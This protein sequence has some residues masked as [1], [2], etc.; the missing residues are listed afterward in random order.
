[1]F[2][3]WVLLLLAAP[4]WAGEPSTTSIT[5]L[6]L[7][8]LHGR[9]LPFLDKAISETTPVGGAPRLA[10]MIADE[11]GKNPN[12]T[13]L[14]AAGDMFQGAPVS[15]VFRGQPVIAVMNAL[16]FDAMALGNHE[17][18]WGRAVL[19]QLARAAEF[20]F[21]AANVKDHEI[22]GTP[23]TKPYVILTRNNLR[24]AVLGLTTP[25]TPFIAKPDYVA[26]F[27][28]RDPVEI[29]PGL[30]KEARGYGADFIVLLS[31]LGL[32]G[33]MRVAQQV[34][35]I[36]VIIGGHSHTVM[37]Q[38]LRVNETVIV[39]AGSY[40][41]YLGVLKLELQPGAGRIVDYTRENELKTASAGPD[42]PVDERVAGIVDRFNNQIK[43][44]F[45]RVIGETSVDLARN[46]REESNVGNLVCDAMRDASG[47]DIAFQN[48]GA[49]RADFPKGKITL[50][51]VYTLL[52]FDN[53]VVVM[54][55]T[56]GQIKQI[57]EQSAASEHRILQVSG[58]SVHYD[59]TKPPGSM[60]VAIH[61]DGKPLALSGSY[62]VVTNEF[63]AEG[64]DRFD[65]FREGKHIT[66]GDSLRDIFTAY[67]EKHSPVH[68]E[69]QGRIV[70]VKH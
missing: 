35:G 60:A 30:I 40:G 2:R 14:L 67:V 41:V 26:G 15:N 3:L 43:S 17:F 61:V 24:F 27:T 63:L 44:E 38:P 62:R 1:M 9:L 21:L 19:K 37:T 22:E 8:D 50:E 18:D 53:T 34:P 33:D 42:D 10:R 65:L 36:H 20:P 13:L 6:H 11:R 66:Y 69:R 52:P 58:L 59:L 68:P 70:F 7:N 25:D 55:L 5:V 47:A 48:S 28:F 4:L 29:L 32:D 31:H 39:Q 16:T 57:L 51:Q 23:I 45:A 46:S 56:G 64:G 49:I 54:D 12:G